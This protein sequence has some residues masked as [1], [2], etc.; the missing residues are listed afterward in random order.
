[1]NKYLPKTIII[2]G[3]GLWSIAFALLVTALLSYTYFLASSVVYVAATKGMVRDIASLHVSIGSLEA[4]YLGE[5]NKLDEAQI[6]DHGLAKIA[7]VYY[8]SAPET[9]LTL[10]RPRR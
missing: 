10:A 6:G 5:L 8:V 9:A 3:P 1:M 4:K 7:T 2:P